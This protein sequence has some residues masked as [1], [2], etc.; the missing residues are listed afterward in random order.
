MRWIM[1][2]L[3]LISTAVL[4]RIL[5][6]E[7]FGLVAMAVV[8][9][10]LA[11]A[12]LSIGIDFAVIRERNL[13]PNFA[14]T[15]WTLKILQSLT[16]AMLLVA[17]SPFTPA[18]F[19]DERVQAIVLITAIGVL[20]S[21]FTNIGLVMLRREMNFHKDF[22]YNIVARIVSMSMTIGLALWL[23]NYWSLVLA[24][25]FSNI[26]YVLLSYL[27]HAYRPR[28]TLV[29]FRAIWGLSLWM[30]INSIT[31]YLRNQGDRLILAGFIGSHTLGA[32]T[33]AKE[34]S[35]LPSQEIS[36]PVSR[37]L[38]PAFSI[39]KENPEHLKNVF[40][41]TLN[42]VLSV[43]TPAAFGVAATAPEFIP[44]LLGNNPKWALAVPLA[45]LLAFIGA[46]NPIAS[47]C[48]NLLI[49]IEKQKSLAL[50]DAFFTFIGL[51]IFTVVNIYT[52]L[53]PSLY[54]LVATLGLGAI[55]MLILCIK[56]L[57]LRSWFVFQQ[58]LRPLLSAALMYGLLSTDP[59]SS[60]FPSIYSYLAIKIL[61][62]AATYA[63]IL[64][65]IWRLMDCP[66]GVETLI[67]QEIKKRF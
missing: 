62:G 27:F 41:R 56:N 14:N 12:L 25:L 1:R 66:E 65:P 57:E 15:A 16:I 34:I 32:F 19:G 29:C 51:L 4:A 9:R 5:V 20:I 40:V 60:L 42:I 33:V 48:G 59:L 11:E 43:A 52:G 37:T 26:I 28:F 55:M 35:L 8:L 63:A 53:F 21:G 30:L 6:P 58:V 47:H 3:G 50:L 36:L 61:I 18:Y 17:V 22:L 64:V 44:I 2:S 49:V 10:G 23:R 45:S 31:A 7:D 46:L 54:A 67:L 24:S 39:A 13:T 38:V